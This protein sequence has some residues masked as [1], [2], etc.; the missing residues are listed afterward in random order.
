VA[1]QVEGMAMGKVG[2]KTCCLNLHVLNV[3]EAWK[4]AVTV[5]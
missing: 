3:T 5:L 2:M 4:T 1:G